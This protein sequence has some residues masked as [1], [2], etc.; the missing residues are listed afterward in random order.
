MA[1][2]YIELVEAT[3][4]AFLTD[5]QADELNMVHQDIIMTIRSRGGY[6]NLPLGDCQG[7]L[8]S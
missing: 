6:R 1:A 7:I 5:R 3:C 2:W 8:G 4:S